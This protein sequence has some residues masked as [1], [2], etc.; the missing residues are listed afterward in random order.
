MVS[1]RYPG[2]PPHT[3]GADDHP[4]ASEGGRGVVEGMPRTFDEGAAQRAQE[5]V[6]A[7][8]AVSDK[9][10][11]AS[12]AAAK[13]NAEILRTQVE[14]AQHAVRSGFE[15]GMRTLEGMTDNFARA[16]GVAGPDPGLAEQ[17]ARNVEAV[18]GASAVLA[19]GAQDAARVWFDL[20]Q[21]SVRTNLEALGQIARCR[22]MQELVHVHSDLLRQ[23]LQHVIDSG[24]AIARASSDA[25]SEAT[26]AMQ[27][28]GRPGQQGGP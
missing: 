22:S 10:A 6:R 3:K 18:S 9:T 26:R 8:E 7:A 23:N 4:A 15:A 2:G 28:Q 27:S 11:D 13:A 12:R 16:C 24:E 5:A 21:R 25:V 14:T 20:T 1:V 19:K 17:S